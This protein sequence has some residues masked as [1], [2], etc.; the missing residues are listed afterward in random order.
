ME[1]T[2]PYLPGYFRPYAV[3]DNSKKDV[4]IPTT[5]YNAL[6]TRAPPLFL[7]NKAVSAEARAI[8]Y[9]RVL[10]ETDDICGQSETSLIKLAAQPEHLMLHRL[11]ELYICSS[12]I[13]M[14]QLERLQVETN[15]H[16]PFCFPIGYELPLLK[17]EFDIF[18]G[19]WLTIRAQRHFVDWHFQ[20]FND[21]INTW[22][23][24]LDDSYRFS[25]RDLLII[26]ASIKRIKDEEGFRNL[27]LV[28]HEE[29]EEKLRPFVVVDDVGTKCLRL[30]REMPSFDVDCSTLIWTLT[31]PCLRKNV[32]ASR[33]PESTV[34]AFADESQN[35]A[36]C[37]RR[38]NAHI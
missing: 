15:Q 4:L 9:Q 37:Q 2:H 18:N 20:L 13:I 38:S 17:L 33:S 10:M 24:S 19:T 26:P 28:H 36:G 6:I 12:G 7:V 29:D 31:A 14:L 27:F 8:A 35:G 16:W 32:Q 1:V 25:S 30:P 21:A 11:R 5:W 3:V 23:D 22:L 34:D